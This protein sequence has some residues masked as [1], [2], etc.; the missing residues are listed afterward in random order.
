MLGGG[1][2]LPLTFPAPYPRT[3][4]SSCA[5]FLVDCEIEAA[6][7]T[8]KGVMAVMGLAGGELSV[9]LPVAWSVAVEA[10]RAAPRLLVVMSQAL[11]RTEEEV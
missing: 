1:P 6:A 7:A 8:L 10:Y 5:G 3:G 11:W 2:G 9:L 4:V